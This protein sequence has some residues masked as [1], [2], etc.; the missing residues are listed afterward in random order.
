MT[1]K[2]IPKPTPTMIVVKTDVKKLKIT[3]VANTGMF[4]IIAGINSRP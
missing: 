3:L 1:C 2:F 4:A